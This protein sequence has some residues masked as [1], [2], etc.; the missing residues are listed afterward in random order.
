MSNENKNSNEK[1]QRYLN[2]LA[3]DLLVM[4]SQ[5]CRL[6]GRNFLKFFPQV[7]SAIVI[8]HLSTNAWADLSIYV[9][10]TSFG[11]MTGSML[12]AI[13]IFPLKY[14]TAKMDNAPPIRKKQLLGVFFQ[15]CVWLTTVLAVMPL[16]LCNI[17]F[18]ERLLHPV[19]K[20]S[21]AYQHSA[22]M[23]VYYNCPNLL[24]KIYGKIIESSIGYKERHCIGYKF[25]PIFHFLNH[26]IA[27]TLFIAKSNTFQVYHIAIIISG[28]SFMLSKKKLYLSLL[29]FFF[30]LQ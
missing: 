29:S 12:G 6:I 16:L 20:G 23:F 4:L 26:C 15:R 5:L 7:L 3:G 17:V 14:Q 1:N 9:I 30:F 22:L 28:L 27:Y 13:W 11:Y 2:R 8:E 10:G 18:P 24:C 19:L 25:I 21:T